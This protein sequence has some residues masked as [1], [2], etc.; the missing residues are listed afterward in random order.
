M[1]AFAPCKKLPKS[2]CCATGASASTACAATP[3]R[4]R[5]ADILAW[6]SSPASARA[7]PKVEAG[8]GALAAAAM[9]WADHGTAPDELAA[10]RQLSAALGVEAVLA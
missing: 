6:A 2:A 5:D 10:L 1:A 8:G 7:L 4:C 9:M 3:S